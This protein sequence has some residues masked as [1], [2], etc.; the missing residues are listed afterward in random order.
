MPIKPLSETH[1]FLSS[2]FT[3]LRD[4]TG[5]R[6]A[7]PLSGALQKYG[8]E[9]GRTLSTLRAETVR[10]S[11]CPNLRLPASLAAMLLAF[12]VQVQA[13]VP[14]APSNLRL[15]STTVNS[16]TFSWNDNAIDESSQPLY[17]SEGGQ[18][19]FLLTAYAPGVTR[20]SLQ[21]LNVGVNYRI[22][23]TARNSSGESSPSNILDV[24]IPRPDLRAAMT[25]SPPL[26]DTTDLVTFYDRSLGSPRTWKWEFSDGVTSTEQN[27]SRRF[28]S[29]GTYR[30]T[31]TVTSAAKSSQDSAEIRVGG[32]SAVAP[33]LTAA[34]DCGACS[35]TAGDALTFTDTSKGSPTIWKWSFGDGTTSNQSSP[36]HRY[37]IEGTF[38]VALETGRADGARSVA[39][40]TVLVQPR[41][42]FVRKLI[43]VVVRSSGAGNSYWRSEVSFS[44]RGSV[45][46]DLALTLMRSDPALPAS[47]L[48]LSLLPGTTSHYADILQDRFDISDGS[49]AL[50]LETTTQQLDALSVYSRTYTGDVLTGTYGQPVPALDVPRN[51][52]TSFIPGIIHS[53][54]YRTNLG[55]VNHG[56]QPASAQLTLWSGQEVLTANI[57][58]P[59]GSFR[60]QSLATLFPGLNLDSTAR[61]IRLITSNPDVTMYASVIDN[62]TLDPTYHSMAVIQHGVE[63]L[64]VPSVGRTRGASDTFW[65]SDLTLLNAV[66]SD[67]TMQATLRAGSDTVVRTIV[68]RA[69]EQLTFTDVIGWFGLEGDRTGSL[70]LQRVMGTLPLLSSR[71]YTTREGGGTLGQSIEGVQPARSKSSAFLGA[72][73]ADALFRSNVGFLSA[74]P[75]GTIDLTLR[76]FQGDLVGAVQITLGANAQLQR[77]LSEWFPTLP[78]DAGMLTLTARG[79][80]GTSFLMFG[81]V[82]DNLSGDPLF[83]IGE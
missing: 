20:A 5:A 10:P 28:T 58:L 36:T 13:A 67:L 78:Q 73:R 23:F 25:W 77:P 61:S 63:R 80:D 46:L 26:P 64:L 27:F 15:L 52:T 54:G 65:R 2:A 24:F 43:P 48:K 1:R 74:G 22:Y 71:T 69:G 32:T 6:C 34:F 18:P 35:L 42:F 68:M 50:L 41:K 37:E 45:P 55:F 49:G 75:A 56:V 44:N 51:D 11:V 39:S 4:V 79:I 9:S 81:S 30:V 14:S 8:P 7:R 3:Y 72:L 47:R 31:L 83:L 57:S 62:V 66:N 59:P 60:Q 82:I 12:A 40:R 29:P 76:T 70:E 33:T 16:F 21:H 53:T 17:L 38:N 19:F